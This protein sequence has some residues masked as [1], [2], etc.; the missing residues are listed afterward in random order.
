MASVLK[1][2]A[3]RVSATESG[4]DS[5]ARNASGL[6]GFNLN[7]FASEGQKHLQECSRQVRQM[8]EQAEEDAKQIRKEAEQKGREEGL[9]KA[10]AQL[11]Q[12]IKAEG[13]QRAKSGLKM[14]EDAIAQMHDNYS[15]WMQQYTELL[16]GIA[17]AAAEKI[18]RRKLEQESDLLLT[19][20]TEAV[21]STRSAQ[22]LSVAVHPE[23]LVDLGDKLDELLAS[24]DLPESTQVVPDASLGRTEVVVRQTGGE[25]QAGLE[26]QISRLAELLQ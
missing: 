26:A 3:N 13:D 24:P 17:L 25:I 14:I 6:A 19:W 5:A 21:M 22:R 7:D 4:L 15:Q 9:R 23:T 10:E 11:E 2:E 18:T 20:V 12:R 1:S 8:L 16:N